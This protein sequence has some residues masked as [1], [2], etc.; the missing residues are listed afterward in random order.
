MTADRDAGSDAPEQSALLRGRA[1]FDARAWRDAVD[2][3]AEADRQA[4]LAGE[5]LERMGTAAGLIGDDVL[6]VRA[7]D[8][9]HQVYSQEE[10]HARAAR[11]IFFGALR[12]NAMGE[13]ARAQAF[14][15]RAE[16]SA[17]R[18][19]P[20]SAERVLPRVPVVFRLLATG[21]N[22]E[23]EAA[24]RE[25]IA[26]AERAGDRDLVAFGRMLLGRA[27]LK[28]GEVD[29]GLAQLDDAMLTATGDQLSPVLTGIV[30]CTVLAACAQVYALDRAR[31]WTNAFTSWCDGQ[32]QLGSFAG[33]CHVHRAELLELGGAWGEAVEEARRAEQRM[34]SSSD[35]GASAGAHYQQAEIHRLRGELREAEERYTAASR[36]GR[37]P[38]PGLALL[39][40]AQGNAEA[41]ASAMRRVLLTTQGG[42][43]RARYLPA[44][45]EIMLA[46]ADLEEA[47]KASEELEQTARSLGLEVMRAIAGQACAQVSLASGSPERAVAP[48]REALAIWQGIGAPYITARIHVQLAR[49]FEALG[50]ADG[51]QLE[52]CAARET[53]EELGAAIDLA[54]L[55]TLAECATVERPAALS[56]GP[57]AGARAGQHGLSARELQVLR[58]VATGKTN[59]A[60]AKELFLSEKT[61]DR[62]V[63]NI[64]QKLDVSSR[65]AATAYAYQHA[66]I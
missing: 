65:A 5:D 18:T 8:R 21:Q 39:R 31:E 19:P 36:A 42:L 41:A 56:A 25:I 50:D 46:I 61:V 35:P 29:R 24:A 52:L 6:M 4:P 26:V 45:V 44:H 63:S 33:A 13:R 62:H 59:R 28:L 37:E 34:S 48:L 60:I 54:T 38:L 12:L 7:C 2:L 53:F 47:R 17:E 9:A 27:L 32:P 14:H 20:D 1:A 3:L 11:A 51:A 43:E 66:L 55:P 49:A 10:Q 15:A 57:A 23:A 58:L 40:L 64:F 22:A 16:R 30:Y